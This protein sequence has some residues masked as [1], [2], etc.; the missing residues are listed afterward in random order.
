MTYRTLTYQNSF[1]PLLSFCFILL[2]GCGGMNTN[3]GNNAQ[4]SNL[5][6][7]NGNATVPSVN[8][9]IDGK[10]I[11]NNLTFLTQTGY[12]QVPSGAHELTLNGW[13]DP[14]NVSGPENFLGGQKSTLV[15][16]GCGIFG[17]STFQLITDDVTPPAAG[18]FKLRIVYGAIETVGSEVYLLPLG[19]LPSGTPTFGAMAMASGTSPSPYL[20]FPAGTYHIV[21]TQLGNTTVQFDS[22][23]I[24]FSSG[25]NRTYYIFQNGGQLS[26]EFFCDSEFKPILVSD[27]N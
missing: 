24:D 17:R 1:L 11:L 7:V 22:G 25:Q 8:V 15:F 23:P 5:R 21:L 6:V 18:N 26:G 27:L 4:P 19:A 10:S 2:C 12:V 3:S 13:L 20:A 9:L 14:P 16:E